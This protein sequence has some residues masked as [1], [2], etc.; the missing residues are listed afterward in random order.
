LQSGSFNK[1]GY[2]RLDFSWNAALSSEIKSEIEEISNLAI[3]QDLAVS[4]AFMSLPEAREWGAVALFG[5]TYDESVRVIQIGGPWS[6]EL[7]GGTHV[8]RSS[9]IG[10]VSITNES[11]VGSGSR[12]IEALVGMQALH[13]LTQERILFHQI[14]D[15]L[16]T[17]PLSATEKLETLLTEIKETQRLLAQAQASQLAT[18]VPELLASALS[19]GSFKLIAQ[20]VANVP[21]VDTLRDLAIK[22]RDQLS[23]ESAVVALV[24]VV[25]GKPCLVVTCNSTAQGNGA[26]AGDLVKL[27]A[28]VLGGGGGGKSDIAQGAGSDVTKIAEALTAIT[29]SLR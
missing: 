20:A 17:S 29:E 6:R 7:C 16:K 12:R 21:T 22:L 26:Q 1:P 14:A 3:R 2:L 27:G 10:L 15:Q 24:S 23:T 8:A 5:E 9:Q 19:V 25:D 28:Q 11:S 13:A 18:Q 4:A